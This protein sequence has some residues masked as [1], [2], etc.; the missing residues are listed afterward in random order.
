MTSAAPLGRRFVS[1]NL[2]IDDWD[3]VYKICQDIMALTS[4]YLRPR[5]KILYGEVVRLASGTGFYYAK[6]SFLLDVC[7]YVDTASGVVN[8]ISERTLQSMLAEL[9]DKGNIRMDT[10]LIP[11]RS[12]EIGRRIFVGQMLALEPSEDGANGGQKISPHTY[13][14]K[15]QTEFSEILGYSIGE[16]LCLR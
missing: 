8:R 3:G 6:N 7:T 4:P 11:G 15:V 5:T 13:A 10:G 12:G 1:N 16:F 9:R 14:L 2:Y